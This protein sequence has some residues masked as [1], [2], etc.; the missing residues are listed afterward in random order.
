MYFHVQP[1]SRR[2]C[3]GREPAGGV[4]DSYDGFGELLS[5]TDSLGTFSTTLSYLYDGDGNRS[6]LTFPD[7]NF[8]TYSYDGLD[9]ENAILQG[10]STG[11]ITIAYDQLGRR[12]SLG[13]AGAGTTTYGYD[14]ASRLQALTD[15]LASTTGPND[16]TLNFGYY[17]SSQL[18]TKAT[19]N[20]AYDWTAPSSFTRTYATNGLNQ[21]TGA[22]GV[23]FAYD[24]NGNLTQSGSTY[25]C[26]DTENRLVGSGTTSSDC[27]S[28]AALTYDPAGRLVATAKSGTT[29]QLV[30]DGDDLVA[31][32]N[33][34]T[35]QRRYIHGPGTDDPLVQYEG[36]GVASTA[37]R[38][39]YADEQG[40]IIATTD[41]AGALLLNGI[42]KYDEYGIPQTDSS[43]V[44]L[45]SGRFQYTGQQWIGDL[46]MYY[47]KAR[48]YSPTLGRFMQTD[49]IGYEAGDP[50]LY[51]YVNDDPTDKTDP[52]GNSPLEFGFGILDAMSLASDI[53]D[54]ASVGSIAMDVGN[55]ALDVAPIPGLSE[56]AHVAEAARAAEHGLD[57]AKVTSRELRAAGRADFKA[58]RETALSGRAKC[59]YCDKPATQGDHI[60]S[61]KSYADDV[62]AGKIRRSDAVRQANAPENVTGACASCNLSKGAKTLSETPG[63]DK[64]VPPNMSGP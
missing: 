52:I 38:Y 6:R 29:T 64:W 15:R 9:R 19:T 59:S 25:Y 3:G 61:L 50:N 8:F 21:Y 7:T 16:Q 44:S 31:E 23:S 43:G 56:V 1:G 45:N 28:L 55:L 20:S 36:S 54:G 40:S 13:R 27:S 17:A 24:A 4:R 58:S 47:Y 33:G 57:A 14:N 63:P 62:N 42:D 10:A 18:K 46:A 12:A 11:L 39:L 22:A 35:L 5:T 34:S 41:N 51:A 30:Y 53:R 2:A 32:Y 48:F 37:A 60:K 26:Y 49:P